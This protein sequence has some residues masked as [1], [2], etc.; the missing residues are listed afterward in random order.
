MF[1]HHELLPA[2]VIMLARTGQETKYWNVLWT[3]H[4]QTVW[5]GSPVRAQAK[6]QSLIKKTAGSLSDIRALCGDLMWQ[7]PHDIV[8]W[9]MT[10]DS[11]KQVMTMVVVVGR[12]RWVG[13]LCIMSQARTPAHSGHNLLLSPVNLINFAL[14]WHLVC[15]LLLLCSVLSTLQAG[16]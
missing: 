1:S 11:H 14:I 8:R 13:Q 16:N 2:M 6:V 15:S 12:A 7:I 4:G 3:L 9:V 5:A 10:D